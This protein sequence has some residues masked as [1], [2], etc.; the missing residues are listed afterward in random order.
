MEQQSQHARLGLVGTVLRWYRTLEERLESRA[1]TSEGK[2]WIRYSVRIGVIL[3]GIAVAIG[4]LDTVFMPWYVGHNAV[5]RTPNVVGMSYGQAVRLLQDNGFTVRVSSEN[6]HNAVPAGHIVTQTPYAGSLVKT[7]RTIYL[8]LSKGKQL[9]EVPNLVGL[10]V[11]DARIALMR[12][13]LSLSSASYQFNNNIPANII[14][15][16]SLPPRQKVGFG[17]RID[18]VVSLGP[19]VV[20]AV[21]P[22]VEGKSLEEAR[23]ILALAGF[24]VGEVIHGEVNETFMPGTVAKQ[25]PAP[26]D[27][28]KVG[29]PVS[30]TVTR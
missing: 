5:V 24:V 12:L 18:V 16:Q 28:V 29:T 27:S 4:F 19:E 30:L 1:Q 3:L 7:S 11:R 15:Q 23:R 13:G 22:D 21:V 17:A 25:V 8:S 26:F 2:E 6:Y 14:F 9:L 10:T 20:Y